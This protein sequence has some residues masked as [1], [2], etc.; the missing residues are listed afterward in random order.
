MEEYIKTLLEQVRCKKAHALIEGEIRVHRPEMAWDM[1]ILVAV[2]S[3]I[4][5][6]LHVLP[7]K[8]IKGA[9]RFALFTVV[10]FVMMLV[11]YRNGWHCKSCFLACC[12]R[13]IVTWVAKP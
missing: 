4:A 10:G 8:N 2:I 7:D 5:I 6:A 3:I 13:H 12:P 9:G 1:V 11:V